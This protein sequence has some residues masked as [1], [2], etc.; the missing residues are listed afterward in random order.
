M[1]SILRTLKELDSFPSL[2]ESIPCI[3]CAMMDLKKKKHSASSSTK[4]HLNIFGYIFNG[5]FVNKCKLET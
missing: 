5:L 2:Q 4:S 1:L 3:R